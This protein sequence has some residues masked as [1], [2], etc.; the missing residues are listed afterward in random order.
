MAIAQR[1]RDLQ[2]PPGDVSTRRDVCGTAGAAGRAPPLL[3]TPA[4]PPKP[5]P[6]AVIDP[7]AGA[8]VVRGIRE[9][10][11]AAAADAAV[12][13]APPPHALAR[14]PRVPPASGTDAVRGGCA[15]DMDARRENDE[16]D[17]YVPPARVVE[18]PLAV[19]GRAPEVPPSPPPN[20]PP[21]AVML[22][23]PL[24]PRTVAVEGRG[25]GRA[26]SSSERPALPPINPAT[27]RGGL[28][29]DPASSA[30]PLNTRGAS[31]GTTG[32]PPADAERYSPPPP[33]VRALDGVRVVPAPSAGEG[34]GTPRCRCSPL[35]GVRAGPPPPGT[36]D[37]GVPQVSAV[38]AVA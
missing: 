15:K 11:G 22:P 37:S 24:L 34:G 27:A 23:S 13:L 20:T 5:P 7:L 38:R 29:A 21:R 12:P 26:A 3:R 32:A 19:D 30:L 17:T 8:V 2:A 25:G 6:R 28:R 36:R 1:S 18:A 4:A 35:V 9:D 16:D 33:G 10:G 31:G 14:T